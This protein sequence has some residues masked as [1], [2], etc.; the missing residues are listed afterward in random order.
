MV[1][2][3]RA[4]TA[5]VHSNQVLF[6][7]RGRK[8][9]Q[10]RNKV[11]LRRPSVVAQGRPESTACRKM[12]SE[13]CFVCGSCCIQWHGS[14]VNAAAIS[15]SAWFHGLGHGWRPWRVNFESPRSC[16]V[17]L[18]GASSRNVVSKLKGWRARVRRR[19]KYDSHTYLDPHG[20]EYKGKGE[21]RTGDGGREA[22]VPGRG[23]AFSSAGHRPQVGMVRDRR[24]C[25]PRRCAP[26]T[27]LVDGRSIYR[28]SQVLR[29]F[30]IRFGLWSLL[31][32][33]SGAGGQVRR[34]I[35]G[36]VA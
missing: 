23:S 13:L 32:V 12:A 30:V 4:D 25:C 3:V 35:L 1:R 31:L 22:S 20:K 7:R 33:L 19:S 5:G 27:A 26:A 10:V 21:V 34:H 6:V 24:C 28:S 29:A 14:H 9:S 2:R 18:S 15:S 11:P 16:V 8:R 17:S 36:Y